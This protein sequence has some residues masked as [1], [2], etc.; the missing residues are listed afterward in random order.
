MVRTTRL[1]RRI[2]ALSLIHISAE[3]AFRGEIGIPRVLNMYE[4]YPLW[5]TILTR[6]GFRVTLS[7]RSNHEVFER[8]MESIPSENVCYPA[9]LAHGHIE[10]LLDRNITTIFY[11]CVP[12]EAKEIEGA[13][14]HFN[15]P[16][17]AFYPQVLERNLTRLQEPGVRYL[18]PLLNLDNPEKLE[19]CI[20]DSSH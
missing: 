1:Q 8:G 17:V 13:D 19:M 12:L 2:V 20:R 7:G 5:F 6:L 3:K 4:N 18:A 15:C 9:K 16:V 11:P 10:S 14:N